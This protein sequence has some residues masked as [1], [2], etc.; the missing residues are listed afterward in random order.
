MS[1]YPIY[2]GKQTCTRCHEPVEQEQAVYLELHA[3]SG[4]YFEIGEVLREES[5]GLFPFGSEYIRIVRKNPY[6]WGYVGL[7]KKNGCVR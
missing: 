3:E 4:E 1:T 2:P 6:G 7:A 5:Q